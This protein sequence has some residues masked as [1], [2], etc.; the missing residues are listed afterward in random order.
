MADVFSLRNDIDKAAA[1]PDAQDGARQALI[2][3][4]DRDTS[5]A[6]VAAVAEQLYRL[7]LTT[8]L[9]KK[10]LNAAMELFKRGA[11]KKQADWSPLAR[12]SYALTLHAKGK[13]QQAVFEL[14]KVT[15][16]PTPS[17]A[18]ATAYVF[19]CQVLRDMGAKPSEIEKA[20]KERMTA[21]EALYKNAPAKSEEKAHWGLMLAVAHKEGGS[22]NEAKRL[23]QEVVALGKDA[24]EPTLGTARDLVKGM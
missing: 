6:A 10:D 1:N 7:G 22:R 13:H 9:R 20:D 14:R 11:E 2:S 8:L 19:L 23:L 24:G 17:P 18:A 3:A 4:L 5:D 21:M 15:T 12:T 16:L